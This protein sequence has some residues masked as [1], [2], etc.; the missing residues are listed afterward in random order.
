MCTATL[1]SQKI[2]R[3]L[4]ICFFCFSRPAC[5]FPKPFAES[6]KEEKNCFF[7]YGILRGNLHAHNLPV[8][9]LLFFFSHVA[10]FFLYMYRLRRCLNVSHIQSF[11]IPSFIEKAICLPASE[12]K[13]KACLS[14]CFA[15]SS[16]L[17]SYLCIYYLCFH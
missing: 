10:D 3:Q 13:D 6:S 9:H 7:P 8:L 5:D 4:L 2:K 1:D 15:Y 16:F 17:F 11:E 14:I 12:T